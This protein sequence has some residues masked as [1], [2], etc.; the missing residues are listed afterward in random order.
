MVAFLGESPCGLLAGALI[1]HKTGILCT[2]QGSLL[3][4]NINGLQ[5][6]GIRRNVNNFTYNN[7]TFLWA[8]L[9]LP[10][11]SNL[12]HDVCR[13]HQP[14]FTQGMYSKLFF[15]LILLPFLFLNG[16]CLVL[17]KVLYFSLVQIVFSEVS[18]LSEAAYFDDFSTVHLYPKLHCSFSLANITFFIFALLL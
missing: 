3:E 16:S 8:F 13:A 15:F 5:R 7:G 10:F 14:R 17:D 9:Y 12:S 2:H 18:S 4:L 6:E 11:K 1:N